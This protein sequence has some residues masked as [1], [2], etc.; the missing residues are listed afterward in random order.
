MSVHPQK[1]SY[2][3]LDKLSGELLPRRLALATVPI[4]S[5]G[6]HDSVYYACQVSR[7]EGTQGLLGT[8]LFAEPPRSTVTCVPAIV[9][10]SDR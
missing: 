5:S 4:G 10:H 6:G 3:A 1:L 8:G 7:S 2:A 9:I